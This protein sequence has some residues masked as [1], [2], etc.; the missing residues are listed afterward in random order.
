MK[1]V[2]LS[3]VLFFS[4]IFSVNVFSQEEIIV[5]EEDISASFADTNFLAEVYK[6][7]GKSAG[8][9][10]YAS[11]VAD[12]TELNIFLKKIE[13]LAGIEHFKALQSLNVSFN[14][15]TTLDLSQ[16]TELSFLSV[17]NN[18][19]TALDLSENQNITKLHLNGN[20]FASESDIIVRLPRDADYLF[21]T[22][23]QR[24]PADSIVKEIIKAMTLTAHDCVF[25]QIDGI[26]YVLNTGTAWK[27]NFLISRFILNDSNTVVLVR[28]ASS[29][30][31]NKSG[32]VS[33]SANAINDE[34]LE[35]A[36]LITPEKF[37]HRPIQVRAAVN[38]IIIHYL[39][40]DTQV[41]VYN[42]LGKQIYGKSS[43][44]FQTM[45]LPVEAKG[46]FL[47]KVN[48]QSFKV[49]VP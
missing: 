20:Y 31:H 12:I 42:L 18:Y 38:R 40:A 35:R 37:F 7:T 28:Y 33:I 1:T 21:I 41:E 29:A 15:L 11:D 27:K 25:P 5:P 49:A 9:P 19:L 45:E 36:A 13:N 23:N 4:L 24:P 22:Q 26:E 34:I 6:L 16:N 30:T 48:N 39:P 2:N 46:M 44:L 8:E 14:N 43:G 47:V 32:S 17:A 3:F 10:I